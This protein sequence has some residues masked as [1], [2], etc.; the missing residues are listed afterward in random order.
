MEIAPLEIINKKQEQFEQYVRTLNPNFAFYVDENGCAITESGDILG[1]AKAF[2]VICEN[3]KS[4]DYKGCVNNAKKMTET[5]FSYVTR[6]IK[7]SVTGDNDL[8]SGQLNKAFFSDIEEN[9]DVVFI[10]Y[11]IQGNSVDNKTYRFAGFVCCN[12]LSLKDE[13]GHDKH[14]PDECDE[15]GGDE[16]KGGKTLYVDSICGKVNELGPELDF[17]I[18]Q[19]ERPLRIGNVLLKNVEDYAKMRGF[20]QLKLSALTYVINY[21]RKIGYLHNKGCNDVENAD[22]KRLGNKVSKCIFKSEDAALFTYQLEKRVMLE[23][24]TEGTNDDK[25]DGIASAMLR[26]M[27]GSF[28][29]DKVGTSE[30][31]NNIQNLDAILDYLNSNTIC[32]NDSRQKIPFPIT[33]ENI[34]DICSNND[35]NGDGPIGLYQL[36]TKLGGSGYTVSFDGENIISSRQQGQ[37]VDEDGDVTDMADEGYTMRKCIKDLEYNCKDQE[38][39]VSMDKVCIKPAAQGGS[40]KKR[41]TKKNKKIKKHKKSKKTKKKSKKAN[42]TKKKA[43]K[44]QKKSKKSKK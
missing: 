39:N 27:E 3:P 20:I 37:Q 28:Y 24:C 23:P 33:P 26:A 21:Y 22:I 18:G 38:G 16:G 9:A 30:Y 40:K 35:T 8:C 4:Y 15:E 13:D 43:K 25:K 32:K 19:E 2:C 1:R 42:K 34:G 6:G 10:L 31:N 5:N 29:D 41:K 36:L 14:H 17:R 7:Q 11:N 12:D 44:T